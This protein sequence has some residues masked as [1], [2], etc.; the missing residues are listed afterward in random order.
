MKIALEWLPLIVVLLGAA[1]TYLA[2]IK[3][4]ERLSRREARIAVITQ[5][6]RKLE[7][8][9]HRPT[10]DPRFKEVESALA[11]IQLL[12]SEEEIELAH[13]FMREFQE[14]GDVGLLLQG[15]RNSLRKTLGLPKTEKSLQHFRAM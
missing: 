12:G 13:K 14:G 6:Y 11:D 2:G 7:A 10:G 9:V 3:L 5:A 4:Q 1:L 15:L 8:A